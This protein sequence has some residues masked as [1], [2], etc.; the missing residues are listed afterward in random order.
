MTLKFVLRT[1]L[2]RPVLHLIKA[3]GLSLAFCCILFIVLF[4]NN[5]LT[6]DC[7]HENSDRIYRL[8]TTNSGSFDEKHFARMPYPGFV[9]DMAEYF[10]E[11]ENYTRISPIRGGLIKIEQEFREVQQAFQ[12]D[13][14]F[15]NV[16]DAELLIGNPNEILNNPGI[17]VVSE[18]FAKRLFG[19]ENPIGRIIT[20]PSGQ[21][22]GEDTDFTIH[23]IMKDF[24]QNSHFHP[25]FVSTPRDKGIFN[26]W[27]WTYLLLHQN[28]DPDNIIAGFSDFTSEKLGWEK[29]EN[30]LI[31]HLQAVKRIHLHSNK[32][33][34]I[35][36]GGSESSIYSLAIAVFILLFIALIN[37]AN[38]NIGLAGYIS[39]YFFVCKAA[40]ASRWIKLKHFMAEGMVI[41]FISML[42]S[43]FL[44][45]VAHLYIQRSFDLDLLSHKVLLISLLVIVFVILVL[46]SSLLPFLKRI[47]GRGISRSL[48]VIQYTISIALIIAVLVIQRQ[49]DYAF[50]KSMGSQ[51]ENLI[52]FVNVHT[53]IQGD[54][55]IF[56]QELLKYNS[57]QSVSAM[58]DPPGG[59]ANDMF[60][61]EM[62]GLIAE[63]VAESDRYIGIFP[64]DYSFASIFSLRILAGE[65][66]SKKNADNEG[67]G[68]Y[69][70]NEAAMR[71]LNYSDPFEIV[72]KEF[73]LNFH[74]PS[75]SIP[76]GKIT[77]VVQNFHLSSV[78]KE[79]EPLVLFKRDSMWLM[80]IVVSMK[81]TMQ[82][83][84]LKDIE[85]VWE[86]MFPEYPFQYKYVSTM[87]QEVYRS[88][89]LQAKLLTIFTLVALFICSMG[90]LGMSLLTTQRR[91]KEIGIRKVNGAS[92]GQI[93]KLLNWDFLKW[94]LLSC[95]VAVPIAYYAMTL[96]LESYS[97]KTPLSWWIFV[98]AGSVVILIS[99]LTISAQTMKSA[100]QNPIDALQHD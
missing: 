89:L 39:K 38:L 97:Y 64:C 73:N 20:L 92:V 78:K 10:P 65:D 52:C 49:T 70:V 19:D 95:V 12:C 62:E 37:Y 11:I 67:F 33:R 3:I 31:P 55:E 56:K 59:E 6:Y 14:T 88:E 79:I 1:I 47:K 45:V 83:Q 26:S 40:G 28:T 54:F 16:F 68:E 81:P 63:E 80:N 22:Y 61:F 71:K 77:G 60:P 35:E 36:Q 86:S 8:T 42:V 99:L 32:L 96:W 21:F 85:G 48:I 98:S 4:L 18:S 90:L 72:G 43:A 74:T 25:E 57:V 9:P 58:M 15:F 100:C 7:F 5:E 24:P 76:K 53:S 75:I 13:S 51:N 41:I 2:K 27:A 84:A 69:L 82:E 46:L 17:A 94:I 91:I 30:E 29:S 87:Y 23:G 34:E 50:K 93:V 66:F 44:V